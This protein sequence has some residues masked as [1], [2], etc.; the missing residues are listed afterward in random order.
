MQVVHQACMAQTRHTLR[1]L[2]KLH[3][4]VGTWYAIIGLHL[5]RP[6]HPASSCPGNQGAHQG[7][8]R[9]ASSSLQRHTCHTSSLCASLWEGWQRSTPQW[10]A[11]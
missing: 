1:L 9:A 6:Q 10:T 8:Q 4:C 7:V 11:A 5:C 2:T 3:A